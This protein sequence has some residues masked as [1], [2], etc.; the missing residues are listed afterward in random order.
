M[1]MAC[2]WIAPEATASP[3]TQGAQAPAAGEMSFVET[4]RYEEA[5]AKSRHW[6]GTPL[7]S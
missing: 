3:V 4:H 1:A 7:S 6:P 5:T 2:E